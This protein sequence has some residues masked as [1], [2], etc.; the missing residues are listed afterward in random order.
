VVAVSVVESG[1]VQAT[2][3]SETKLIEAK[4]QYTTAPHEQNRGR[5][6]QT[7]DLNVKGNSVQGAAPPK[8]TTVWYVAVRDER[9]AIASSAPI[10]P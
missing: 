10:V 4:L 8:E 1:R 5:A 6:W 9:K 3:K 7:F 2:V